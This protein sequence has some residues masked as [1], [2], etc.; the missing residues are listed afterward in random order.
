MKVLCEMINA[1]KV[2][3]RN[4]YSKE[5]MTYEGMKEQTVLIM[6]ENVNQKA[7]AGENGAAAEL[8]GRRSAHAVPGQRRHK[9]D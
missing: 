4:S 1:G 2:L 6:D 3:K 9:G 7:K 8:H 5:A